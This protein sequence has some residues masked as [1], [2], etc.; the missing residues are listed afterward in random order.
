[1]EVIYLIILLVAYSVGTLT[2]FLEFICYFRKLEYIETILLTVAFLFLISTMVLTYY[3]NPQIEEGPQSSSV[4]VLIGILGVAVATPFNVFAERQVKVNSALKK[5]ILGITVLLLVGIIVASI[6]DVLLLAQNIIV[7]FLF[8]TVISSMLIVRRSKPMARIAHRER[9]ERITAV[10]CMIVLPFALIVDF[11][12][13]LFKLSKSSMANLGL[14]VPLLFILL[15]TG[16]LLDDIKRLSLFKPSN[17]IQDQNLSNYKFTSRETEVVRLLVKGMTYKQI[18]EALFISI[19][20]VKTHVS[21]I[22]KKAEVNNKIEL[23]N[24]LS[25]S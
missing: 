24:L 4:Y 18:G 19:P 1:M 5:T 16:K 3:L 10:V 15:A 7:T 8:I 22:Y 9:I 21:K 25:F 20:T 6:F 2:L 23:I 13:E 14:T 11:F 17:D 12:P